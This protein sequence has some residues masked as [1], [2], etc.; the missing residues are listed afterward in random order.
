MQGFSGPPQHHV[1]PQP[2]PLPRAL[3][4][5]EY[6]F[7]RD[8]ASKPPL[9]PLYRGPYLV[10]RRSEKFFILQIGDKKDAVS[11][12]RLKPVFSSNPVVPGVP[13]VRGRPRLVPASVPGPPTDRPPVKKV[14]FSP[15][16]KVRFSPVPAP[17]EP[18]Q[19]S[20]RSSASLRC[21]PPSPSGGSNC[22][23]AQLWMTTFGTVCSFFPSLKTM[24]KI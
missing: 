13:P 24:M 4:E 22:G 12:D 8:D 5:A 11:V 16:K 18:S 7:V 23:S 20:S 21:P 15:I 2:Q 9:S 17:P 19:V 3:M 14:T 6:V 1:T 10:L